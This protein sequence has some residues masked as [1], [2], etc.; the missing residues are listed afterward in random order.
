MG[1]L[2]F[3]TNKLAEHQKLTMKN[4]FE[5]K[6]KWKG[7]GEVTTFSHINGGEIL[8]GIHIQIPKDKINE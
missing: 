5:I 7:K 1:K 4:Y 2:D 8:L 6:E 3:S